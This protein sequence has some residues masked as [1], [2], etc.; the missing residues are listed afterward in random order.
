MRREPPAANERGA[1]YGSIRSHDAEGRGTS[2]AA[3]GLAGC[4]GAGRAPAR[5]TLKYGPIELSGSVDSQTLGRANEI[6]EWQFIQNRNTA[7]LRLDYEWFQNGKFIDR[8]ERPVHQALEALRPVPRRLRQLLGHRPGRRAEGRDRRTTTGSAARSAA[9][10]SAQVVHDRRLHLRCRAI[11]HC[12][13]DGNVLRSGIYSRLNT[14]GAQRAWRTRTPCA[15]PTSTSRSPMRR[16]A[17]ALGRQ[18]VI[19]GESDQFRLMDIINPLDTTWHLQQEEWD[20]IRIPLWLIKSIWDMGDIGPISNAFA[21]VVWNPG[22]F[23]SPATRC[24]SCPRRGPFRSPT[25][26]A[27][28]RSRSPTPTRPTPC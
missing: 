28:D 1:R 25:R 18:Q 11:L 6:D 9:R 15:R 21:E 12:P 4:A 10:S 27:P 23:V 2:A 24:T 26:C 19:W 7:L 16:S 8:L 22:D 5:A 20:K 17:S 13:P 3:A 14:R